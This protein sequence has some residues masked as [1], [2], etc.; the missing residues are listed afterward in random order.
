M[1]G[2]VIVSEEARRRVDTARVRDLAFKIK[3]SLNYD[4]DD[5]EALARVLIEAADRGITAT[6]AYVYQRLVELDVAP[7]AAER[8]SKVL[9]E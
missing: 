4:D 9:P 3:S 8:M 5:A 2:D 1:D 6:R 7:A